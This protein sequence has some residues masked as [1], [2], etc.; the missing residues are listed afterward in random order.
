[1]S[2]II[3]VEIV[4]LTTI[5]FVLPNYSIDYPV[6]EIS[7]IESSV[8]N[9]NNSN[10]S[11]IIEQRSGL[12]V[13]YAASYPNGPII[14][15]L[16][17]SGL[18][19]C[20][21]SY[22]HLR[23]IYPNIM[24]ISISTNIMNITA[25]PTFNFCPISTN[26][27]RDLIRIFPL[28]FDHIMIAFLRNN[29]G[30]GPETHEEVGTLIDWE[31]SVIQEISLGFINFTTSDTSS[32]G[33]LVVDSFQGYGF[34][35]VN[36]VSQN[37]YIRWKKYSISDK[38]N[39]SF[40][41]GSNFSII[42]SHQYKIIATIDGGYCFIMAGPS[43]IQWV[44]HALFIR[45]PNYNDTTQ[46]VLIYQDMSQVVSINI[47]T[48]DI[49]YYD[50]GLACIFSIKANNTSNIYSKVSFFSSGI[51]KESNINDTAFNVDKIYQ[52][53]SGGFLLIVRLK[54]NNIFTGYI[55]DI[56]GKIFNI[57]DSP[58][59]LGNRVIPNGMFFKNTVWM[60]SDANSTIPNT[61]N[62]TL[63]TT[64]V[65]KFVDL[66]HVPNNLNI[67]TTFPNATHTFSTSE[68][69]IN[70]T[71]YNP[72]AL[73]IEN[74]SIYQDSG[75]DS[76]L[77]LYYN[78]QNN[79]DK[80]NISLDSKTSSIKVL[81]STF[82]SPQN[83]Y[84]VVMD[85]NFIKDLISGEPLSGARWSLTTESKL[86]ED[87]GGKYIICAKY[88]LARLNEE[89]SSYFYSL[90]KAKRSDYLEQLKYELAYSV[91]L[92]SSNIV[93]SSF[94]QWDH[95]FNN[96]ILLNFQ[97]LPGNDR[98]KN[99]TVLNVVKIL[100]D[101]ITNKNVTMISKLEKIS[102]L[103]NQYGFRLKSDVD[104]W[105]SYGPCSGFVPIF[106]VI[107]SLLPYRKIVSLILDSN[108]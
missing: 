107:L 81:S 72:I 34:I 82:A 58:P 75:I 71:F 46:P 28:S 105:A 43:G 30:N 2:R 5:L 60:F 92:D 100:N 104:I 8:I 42:P 98:I 53:W 14:L 16:I 41:Y 3:L 68:L 77:K 37:E 4:F 47:E 49:T 39:V 12:H 55:Y 29:N 106:L 40:S 24:S 74:I 54:T 103:D 17:S 73:S 26:P 89:E 35:W 52:L 101:L 50:P 88:A 23:L 93:A 62:W 9:N 87:L 51:V 13:F 38:R 63:T 96:K 99:L 91:P 33:T 78:A 70:V 32:L 44:A 67:N 48:C 86:A 57:W 11:W 83:R 31:G 36:R 6:N 22:L 61:S 10:T 85:N 25:I 56:Q 45:P 59:L 21:E 84:Y 108:F 7:Y 97:I 79:N 1:M 94:F 90:S 65:K 76:I 69:L 64:I 20:S 95:H 66:D 80:F 19:N 27:P 102:K 15:R 18:N